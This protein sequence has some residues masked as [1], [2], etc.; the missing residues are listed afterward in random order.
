MRFFVF[1]VNF[2]ALSVFAAEPVNWGHYPKVNALAFEPGELRYGNLA[3]I[4]PDVISGWIRAD[5]RK[6]TPSNRLRAALAGIRKDY[7]TSVALRAVLTADVLNAI[8]DLHPT[9]RNHDLQAANG[10]V[11]LGRTFEGDD[12][13][14]ALGVSFDDGEFYFGFLECR[15]VTASSPTINFTN[16]ADWKKLTFPE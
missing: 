4:D 15:D 12:D 14:H 16:S 2:V 10:V 8:S 3:N 5:N 7:A 9:F 6:L 11:F 1:I 13:R